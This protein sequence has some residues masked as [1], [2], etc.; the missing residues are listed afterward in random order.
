M[1]TCGCGLKEISSSIRWPMIDSDHE[2]L[3]KLGGA[4]WIIIT[5]RDH[6]REAAV[7]KSRTGAKIVV[8][9]ADADALS[10][11]A[12]RLIADGEEVVVGLRAI[13]LPFGKSPGEIA[14]HFPDKRAILAGDLIV[15]EPV[16]QL[17]LLTDEK[18]ES[19]TQAALA[20]RKILALSF[21]AIL[22]GDGHSILQDARQ[23]LVECLQRRTDIYINRIN[24][25]E[26]EW[27]KR[28]AP[29]PYDFEEKDI[30]P[31]IGG[32][33]LGYRLIRFAAEQRELP[34]APAPFWRGDVPC[35]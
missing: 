6:E 23:R 12:D 2:Q 32:K 17:S 20:V 13:H 11:K 29:T 3:N 21:D 5:N 35:D 27:V 24:I 18:L 7:F 33:H 31:L 15:G 8:H 14:L 19:P 10:V 28:N 34:N 4:A 22:V 30:D 16:G 25:D 26:I 9:R 1:D